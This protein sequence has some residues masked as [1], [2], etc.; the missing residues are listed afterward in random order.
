[1]LTP[2]E[3]SIHQAPLIFEPG[4]NFAYSNP[5]MALL[6]YAVTA[7][8]IGNRHED[9]RSLLESRIMNPIGAERDEW[10]TGVA[11]ASPPELLPGLGGCCFI[12]ANGTVNSSSVRK[13]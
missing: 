13:W 1:M 7:S 8:L 11:E 10:S 5:G 9:I 12:K 6:S 3:I 4:M 2:F